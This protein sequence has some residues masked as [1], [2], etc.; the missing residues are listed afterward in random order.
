MACADT[1]LAALK[2]EDVRLG[3]DGC[4]Q[5]HVVRGKGG[6]ERWIHALDSKP[7]EAA[8]AA[9]EAGRELVVEHIPKY[10]PIHEYRAQYA[11]SYY[12]SIARDVT[13]LP[14]KETYICRG[15]RAGQVYD[16]AAMLET[17]HQVWV[18]VG[19]M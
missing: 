9:Q 18:T 3:P 5:V 12:E 15:D 6:K 1:S 7:Y 4:A 14:E 11:R 8:R 16:R 13:E 10:A 19:L 17:S 2:P